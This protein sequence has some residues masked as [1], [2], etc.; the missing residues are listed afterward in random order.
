[1]HIEYYLFILILT[2]QYILCQDITSQV[3]NNRI[4]S[5]SIAPGETQYYHFNIPATNQIF[6]SAS[7]IYISIT[8]CTQPYTGS[9]IIPPLNLYIS[10]T[11]SNSLPNAGN[12]Q[13]RGEYSL[14]RL[15]WIGSSSEVWIGVGAPAN[16]DWVDSWT[17]EIGVSAENVLHPV[18]INPKKEAEEGSPY[19]LLDDTDN[20]H[21]L[22]LSNSFDGTPSNATLLISQNTPI[23]LSHSLC[24]ARRNEV[25]AY[26]VHSTLTTRGPGGKTRHQFYV[27]G[28]TERTQY[29]AYML[30]TSGSVVGM[31]TSVSVRTKYATNCKLIYDLEFCNEVA[32]SVPYNPSTYSPDNITGLATAYDNHAMETY[33]PFGTAISQYNCQTSQYSLVRNCTDC[34]RDYKSWLCSV[35]IPRCTDASA[36]GGLEQHSSDMIAAPATRSVLDTNARDNWIVDTMKPGTWTELLPCIDLCYHVVQSCPPFMQFF[37]PVGD[38]AALQYGYWQSGFV[39]I[40]DTVLGFDIDNPTC[41]RGGVNASRLVISG[42]SLVRMDKGVIVFIT[43]LVLLMIK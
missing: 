6:N 23:E 37:C 19:I 2:C 10:N 43:L 3:N 32:Y 7:R 36:T 15:S 25:P 22:F 11:S 41:N 30:I 24:A 5:A 26:T 12:S 1:M 28:L 35:T 34:T 27:S 17:Y 9:H 20:Q 4:L 29:Q 8:T 39:S 33:K 38:L 31:T 42:T 16:D 14:G 21:A 40:N 18:Y 13:P